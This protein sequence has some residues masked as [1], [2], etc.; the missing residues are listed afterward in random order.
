M[1]IIFNAKS[2]LVATTNF[3]YNIR[4]WTD[5]TVSMVASNANQIDQ[6]LNLVGIDI[7]GP[8]RFPNKLYF[9]EF[10]EREKLAVQGSRGIFN[11]S[12][13]CNFNHPSTT[14]DPNSV[15]KFFFNG[16]VQI[17]S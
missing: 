4:S 14:V 1:V 11:M 5:K 7:V 16:G 12:I 3:L 9:S 8:N 6:L 15:L 17:P 2:L 13:I 10:Y